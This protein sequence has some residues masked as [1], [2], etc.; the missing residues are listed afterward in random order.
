MSRRR[1]T[2]T[3]DQIERARE[4][5]RARSARRRSR[6]KMGTVLVKLPAELADKLCDDEFVTQRVIAILR[7][8][9]ARERDGA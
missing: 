9:M 3:S 5:D 7:A 4:Q 1:S 6:I 8:H 2:M